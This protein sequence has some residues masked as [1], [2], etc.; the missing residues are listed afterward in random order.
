MKSLILIVVVLFLI[1]WFSFAF[2]NASSIDNC[3]D[4]GYCWDYIRNRCEKVNQEMCIKNSADCKKYYNGK[5]D[6]LHQ[7]CYIK[8]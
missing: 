6:S 1:L 2:S 5:W 4:N 7:Y 3:L 8:K